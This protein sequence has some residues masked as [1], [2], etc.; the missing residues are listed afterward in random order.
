M[1]YRDDNLTFP[2]PSRVDRIEAMRPSE[3]REIHNLAQQLMQ[4]DP[5]RSFIPLHFGEPD[6]GTPQFIIDA[7]CKAL[8][9]GAVFYEPNSGRQDLKEELV[10]YYHRYYGIDLTPDHFVVTCGGTQ[11]IALSLLALLSPGDDVINITP[12]WPNFTEAAR[13]AGAR[14]H[15]LPLQFN[16]ERQVF[17]LDFNGFRRTV[18]RVNTPRL[19]IVNSPS[20]PTGWVMTLEEQKMLFALC[21]EHNMYM[22]IDEMYDRLLFTDEPFPTGLRLAE[23]G[24]L[25]PEDWGRIVLING[26]SKTFC[27]TGWRLGYLITAPSLAINMA[28]MQEFVTSHAPSMAQ[29]AGIT[30]LRSGEPFVAESLSRYCNLRDLILERLR[31]L[32]GA[33]I[34]R[35]DGAF[36]EFF[37]LPEAGDSVRFCKDLLLETGVVLAPGKA[38]G[39]G[40]EGW[41][42]LCFA[43]E[44]DRLNEAIDRIEK[45]VRKHN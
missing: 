30:A 29:V 12:N 32:P 20:N 37:R 19:V 17:E 24:A 44:P 7:A 4:Q 18:D 13:I 28:R 5:S 40:G 34:A 15:E 27:M 36:Y 38:F 33:V 42:R 31:A 39:K 6:L 10:N 26:F 25:D 22:L 23:T 2:S 41:L 9:N 11:A 14:V 16:K 3:I 35:P 21:R 43:N 45:F 1:S 8:N